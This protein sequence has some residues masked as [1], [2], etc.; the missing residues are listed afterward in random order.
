METVI[1]NEAHELLKLHAKRA[2]FYFAHISKCYETITLL[3]KKNSELLRKLKL[4][5][6]L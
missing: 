3:E 6:V 2:D 5:K 1:I 4:S